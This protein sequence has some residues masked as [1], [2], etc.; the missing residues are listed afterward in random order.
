MFSRRSLV[1]PSEVAEITDHRIPV[2]VIRSRC[3]CAQTVGERVIVECSA[4]L[5]PVLG[6]IDQGARETI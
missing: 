6:A 1:T 4:G 3:A 5:V 2:K